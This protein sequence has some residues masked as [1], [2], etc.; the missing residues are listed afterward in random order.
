MERPERAEHA[1]PG[2]ARGAPG[3]VPTEAASRRVSASGGQKESKDHTLCEEGPA[4]GLGPDG[5]LQ[6]H[7]TETKRFQ[8]PLNTRQQNVSRRT[9]RPRLHTQGNHF[10]Q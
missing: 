5:P 4:G 7:T 3:A 10:H 8:A 6:G 2:A 9:A 1:Q